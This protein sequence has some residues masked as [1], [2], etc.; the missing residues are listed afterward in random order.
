M[1]QLSSVCTLKVFLKV[2]KQPLDYFPVIKE[3]VGFVVSAETP[4]GQVRGTQNCGLGPTPTD[5]DRQLGMEKPW[6]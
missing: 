1:T 2:I 6:T 3:Y 4:T 5:K